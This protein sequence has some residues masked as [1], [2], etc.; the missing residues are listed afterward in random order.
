MWC[1]IPSGER[2]VDVK[3]ADDLTKR[4]RPD[5]FTKQLLKIIKRGWRRA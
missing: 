1:N 2:T 5:R 3:G 4:H